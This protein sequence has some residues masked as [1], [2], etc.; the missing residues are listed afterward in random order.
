MV[1]LATALGPEYHSEAGLVRDRWLGTVLRSR[2]VP[3]TMLRSGSERDF[4]ILANLVRLIR[5]RQVTI[6]HA[7]EFFM[8]T[9][10]LVASRLTGIPLVAT[11][12]EKNYYPDRFRRRAA[13][14]L[15]GRFAGQM[16]AVSENLKRFLTAQIAIP[17]SRI[18]VIPNGVSI[19][20]KP[21]QEKVSA[22]RTNLGLDEYR[23]VVGTVGRLHPKKGQ[24]YLI[25]GAVHILRR[26]PRTVFLIV[27]DGA[28]REE[29]EAHAHKLGIASHTI[30]LGHREDVYQILAIC[31]VF[32]LPS[33]SEGMP[34]AL[35]EAMGAAVPSVASR[36]DGVNEVVE[37]G[38][39]GLLIPPGDSHAL[40]E[41]IIRLLEDRALAKQ[42]GE[43]ARE[44]VANRFSLE[45]MVRDYREL[46]AALL[47]ERNGGVHV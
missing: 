45:R 7:H 39:T 30:F 47:N 36:F 43:S 10:G 1:H 13:Y 2:G 5:E 14:R 28:L 20:E 29:L 46:Y 44:V 25:E 22:L 27:G 31:D 35:L 23:Q 9:V 32:V 8:N 37:D 41:N 6:L 15:V 16:I 42:I 11:V 38:K 12:H 26:F 40:A 4:A 17:A 34:L 21:S 33:L 3:V 18:K 24:R 19:H